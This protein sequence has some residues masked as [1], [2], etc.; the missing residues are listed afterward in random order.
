MK[1]PMETATGRGDAVSAPATSENAHSMY[2][3]TTSRG[4]RHR[5]EDPTRRCASRKAK[6]VVESGTTNAPG[7]DI[8]TQN[9]HALLFLD[10]VP[11]ELVSHDGEHL[12]SKGV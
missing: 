1:Q 4:L 8:E 7:S 12:V 5:D 10:R 6:D 2:K 11:A 3:P 9:V